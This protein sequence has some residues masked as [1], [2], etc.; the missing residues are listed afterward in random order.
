MQ[1]VN[2]VDLCVETFGESTHPSLLL[3]GGA[4]SSMDLWEDEFCERLASGGR[5]VIRYDHRDT[6]ESTSYPAGAPTYS[7]DDLYGDA[8]A[9]IE[10]LADGRAHVAGMSMGG[11]LAQQ[12]ALE[13]SQRV[14]TLTLLS[15]T[16]LAPDDFDGPELPSSAPGMQEYFSCPPPEPDWEDREA[17]VEY[18]LNHVRQFAGRETVEE[19]HARA[20]AEQTYDRTRDMAA[21]ATNHWI[22]E[23][24]PDP[25]RDRLGTIT[26]PT[27]VIHGTDDPLLPLPHGEALAH[28][29]PG[30]HLLPLDGVGHEVPPPQTWDVV[31]PAFLDHTDRP[32]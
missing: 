4:S 31:V 8:V 14:A 3:I 7:G 2:G 28:E 23:G 27:L 20:L 5:H 13:A 9:L 22:L 26:A 10:R 25:W 18:L 30:A 11:A 16:A 19:D 15:T 29:I 32:A 21:A 1:Q 17:V 24:G 12:I 6:G